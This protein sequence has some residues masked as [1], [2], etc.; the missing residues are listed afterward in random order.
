MYTPSLTLIIIM[1]ATQ[2]YLSILDTGVTFITLLRNE[3]FSISEI[4]LSFTLLGG[5]Y[6]YNSSLFMYFPILGAELITAYWKMNSSSNYLKPHKFWPR[7]INKSS[8]F[9]FS[10]KIVSWYFP[11]SIPKLL[12]CIITRCVYHSSF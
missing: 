12:Y 8:W 2:G 11:I 9:Y 5:H 10:T 6:L 3:V 7:K 1:D 4:F